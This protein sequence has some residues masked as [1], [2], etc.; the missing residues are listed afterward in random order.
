MKKSLYFEII[1]KSESLKSRQQSL[2]KTTKSPR[3]CDIG[4]HRGNRKVEVLRLA[5]SQWWWFNSRCR[6]R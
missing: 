6:A 5:Q 2:Q 3:Q 1:K 4:G